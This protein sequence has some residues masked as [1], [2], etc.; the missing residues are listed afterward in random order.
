M[1]AWLE[2]S[3]MLL[4]AKNVLYG[5]ALDLFYG[6]IKKGNISIKGKFV[7]FE[8]NGAQDKYEYL[9]L[10]MLQN[11]N[12]MEDFF[13]KMQGNANPES[14]KKAL[15]FIENVNM[16]DRLVELSRIFEEWADEALLRVKEKSIRELMLKGISNNPRR[17][18]AVAALLDIE[19]NGN[20]GIF[21]EEELYIFTEILQNDPD[22]RLAR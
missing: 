17:K 13:S 14:R 21:S 4:R 19:K 11:K 20:E 15:E 22:S 7:K 5:R 1:Q 6:E 10:N 18:E 16:I 9:M 2:C 12:S 8:D 3:D